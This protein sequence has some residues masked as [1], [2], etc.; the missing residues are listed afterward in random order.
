MSGID[1][2]SIEC[3][4]INKPDLT[5]VFHLQHSPPLYPVSSLPLTSSRD[6]SVKPACAVRDEDSRYEIEH[7]LNKVGLIATHCPG[8]DSA[9][10]V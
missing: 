6:M 3:I 7:G 9:L 2:F 1:Y 10:L 8:N 4:R 5:Q